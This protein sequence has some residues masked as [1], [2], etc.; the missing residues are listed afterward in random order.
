MV[1]FH[2]DVTFSG[3][4]PRPVAISPARPASA[5][6]VR[7]ANHCILEDCGFTVKTQ[8]RD[9]WTSQY[10]TTIFFKQIIYISQHT[11]P[12]NYK[13]PHYN[14]SNNINRCD[15]QLSYPCFFIMRV[16]PRSYHPFPRGSHAYEEVHVGRQHGRFPVAIAFQA[17]TVNASSSL[18]FTTR[19]RR[20]C[21]YTSK[22]WKNSAV[23]C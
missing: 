5:P 20:P 3:E 9:E 19:A 13:I 6:H 1:T 22:G 8:G 21:R 18:A 15:T 16:W 11:I 17:Q 10:H 7:C 14:N 2:C 23:N 12:W 4:L